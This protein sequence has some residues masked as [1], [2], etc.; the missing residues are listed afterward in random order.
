[1]RVPRAVREL[2]CANPMRVPRAVL[3]EGAANPMRVPRE[4]EEEVFDMVIPFGGAYSLQSSRGM[5]FDNG[6]LSSGNALES[7]RNCTT[8]ILERESAVRARLV[9]DRTGSGVWA[10]RAL[11]S[12]GCL[13]IL[14]RGFWGPG[15]S[16][17]Q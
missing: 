9:G 4:M 14:E 5:V 3:D 6:D 7:L 15:G 16:R 8:T 11:R 17:P 2:T 13:V 12:P 10:L 1:M